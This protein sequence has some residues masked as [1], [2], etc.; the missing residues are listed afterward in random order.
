MSIACSGFDFKNSTVKSKHWDI[1][2]STSKIKDKN[3]SFLFVLLIKTISYSSCCRFIDNS[4][5]VEASYWSCIFCSLSLTVIEIGRHCYNC[6]FNSLPKISLCSFLHFGQNHRRYFL[7]IKLF[8]LSFKLNNNYRFIVTSSLN[9]EGP[10]FHV[11]LDD[12]ISE[13]ST[14]QPLRIEH[15]IIWI[16]SHLVFGCIT[17]KSLSFCECYIGRSGSVTLMISNN[18]NS[19]ILPDTH[20]GVGSTEI[21][22]NSFFRD[23]FLG[24]FEWT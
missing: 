21:N 13:F 19:I 3:M 15:S 12:W 7:G 22:S 10:V 5:N 6:I 4:Q 16:F 11:F 20:T 14:N 24:Y 8:S 17:Y 2:C 18:L 1:K 9:L 23:W